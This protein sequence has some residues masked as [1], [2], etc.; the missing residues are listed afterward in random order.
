MARKKAEAAELPGK[1]IQNGEQDDFAIRVEHVRVLNLIPGDVLILKSQHNITREEIQQFQMSL[2]QH[3]G[4][5]VP[6]FSGDFELEVVRN[7]KRK[8]VKEG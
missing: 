3:F 7:E 8:V 6:V 4:F 5:R 1:P 2:T